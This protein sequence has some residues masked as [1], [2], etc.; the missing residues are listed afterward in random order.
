MQASATFGHFT[1]KLAATEAA[2]SARLDAL[3]QMLSQEREERVQ[4]EAT[5]ASCV[6]E[7]LAVRETVRSLEGQLG[8][9]ST[10][11]RYC[12]LAGHEFMDSKPTTASRLADF[13]SASVSF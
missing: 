11:G 1:E 5:L 10:R 8:F 2:F 7:M 13:W 3:G 9:C 12:V 4:A 6:S